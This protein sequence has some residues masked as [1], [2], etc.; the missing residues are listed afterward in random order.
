M[1]SKVSTYII[2]ASVAGLFSVYGMAE[3][4]EAEADQVCQ[5]YGPQIP[6]DIDNLAGSNQHSFAL[7]PDYDEMDLCNIHF[8]NN[9]EH[10]A[11]DFAI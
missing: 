10:K 1:K 6:R 11:R 5:G 4:A 7:A 8:N 2:I 9:T 3:H